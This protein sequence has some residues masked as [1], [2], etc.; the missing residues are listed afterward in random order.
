MEE[1]K[2]S[3]YDITLVIKTN[4]SKEEIYFKLNILFDVKFLSIEDS[5]DE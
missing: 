5:D 3:T 1:E 4:L 2:D